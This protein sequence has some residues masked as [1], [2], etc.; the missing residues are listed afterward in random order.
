MG[1]IQD[2]LLNSTAAQA[3]LWVQL[4]NNATGTAYVSTGST[5][6]NGLFTVQNVPAGTYTLNS[7][8]TNVGPW[9]T[10][11][12]AYTVADRTPWYDVMDYGAKGDGTTD[13]TAAIQ[14][15]IN[16][17]GATGTVLFPAGFTYKI[18]ST[19]VPPQAGGQ[20]WEG[21]G[22]TIKWAGNTNSV[23]ISNTNV[24]GVTFLNF[25]M[26]GFLLDA[27]SVSGVTPLLL[28][29]W[30]AGYLEDITI[31]HVTGGSTPAVR[32]E[33]NAGTTSA[34]NSTDNV[35]RNLHIRVAPVGL[36]MV[37]QGSG[38]TNNFVTNNT[39]HGLTM[40]AVHVIGIS[41]TQ[42]C[43]S[44]NFHTC[45]I[46][47]DTNNAVGIIFNNSGAP[48]TNKG[49]YNERFFGLGIAS[50]AIT[51]AVGLQFNNSKQIFVQGFYHSPDPFNGTLVQDVHLQ[52]NSYYITETDD[53]IDNNI[54]M[55]SKGAYSYNTGSQFPPGT[56]DFANV[57]AYGAVGNN[58]A[59][60][61][62]A[63]NRAIA[64]IQTP[65]VQPTISGFSS[66]STGGTLSGNT[67][68][69][70]KITATNPWGETT[71]AAEYSFTTPAGTNTNT[72][73]LNWAQI[74]G[75]ANYKIYGRATGAEGFIAFASGSLATSYTDTGS[76][77]P[78]GAPPTLDSTVSGG[79]VY[80]PPGVYRVNSNLTPINYPNVS[81]IGSGTRATK[82]FY[83]GSGDC[84]RIQMNPFTTDQ[85][86]KF[87]GFMIDGLNAA[88][89]AVGIHYG[90]TIGGHLDDIHIR[91]FLGAGSIALWLD[92]R[93]NW[94]ERTLMTRVWLQ[95]ST[96]DML[97]DVNGSS[98]T[99]FAYTRILD[100]RLN[101][102]ANQM[103]M[104]WQN[105][106]N[107]YNSILTVLGNYVGNGVTFWQMGG[108]GNGFL[109]N[110]HMEVQAEL[111]SGTGNGLI[112]NNGSQVSGDGLIALTIGSP[113]NT[114]N[115]LFSVSGS[116]NV[117]GIITRNGA[118]QTLGGIEI[119]AAGTGGSAIVQPG[120]WSDGT[121]LFLS[122]L[123]AG[124]GGIVIR[125]QGSQVAT[126]QSIFQNNGNLQVTA[127]T[128]M[129]TSASGALQFGLTN[130]TSIRLGG[131]G[132]VTGIGISGAAASNIGV[133]VSHSL[134]TSSAVAAGFRVQSTLTAIANNDGIRGIDI[135]ATFT[136]GTGTFTGLD[137][138]LL[139]INGL[140]ATTGTG[141]IATMYAAR[142]DTPT[143]GTTNY[144]IYVNGASA[145]TFTV[146]PTG[147]TNFALQ[148]D[149]S[150]ASAATGLKVTAAAAASGVALAVISS[151]T[152]ENLTI[153]AKG[154]GTVT[155]N[156][157]ATG[158]ITLGHGTTVT[159]GGLTVS[160]GPIIGN[161]SSDAFS[162]A[163]TITVDSTKGN[164]H[165]IAAT[166]NT[167]STL[168]PSAAGTAGQHMWIRITA[169]ATGGN[170][171]TFASTFKPS[172]T[173]TLTANKGHMFHFVS[174]GTNWWE[175]ARTLA[176]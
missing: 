137:V 170:V 163:I 144:G 132:V 94:T 101:V 47:L 23:M 2:F 1:T 80:F 141:T 171:I 147:S 6:V 133:L 108:T 4:V 20:N 99:S 160:A 176:L 40:D 28:Q 118:L 76:P 52:A 68:Y 53:D 111:M 140:I 123:N 168:T 142:F 78:G 69:Y 70:Y 5:G 173:A 30:T 75:A 156:G 64:A 11:D 13:D 109:L 150:A 46:A 56:V 91:N 155:I 43:D 158:G 121:S 86:G 29:S 88:A 18:T 169:D 166:S 33:N 96:T 48:T 164:L 57:M 125:P 36:T 136:V 74:D 65:L 102:N 126:N 10:V 130:A 95:N 162:G 112:I 97:V 120:A 161:S 79:V 87:G 34:N 9:S 89:G 93:T 61:T 21:Y 85:A 124:S 135:P 127:G 106:A 12:T 138:R 77:A 59:D 63:I 37:G 7:G 66:N 117:P 39:F 51:G 8:P 90:D 31:D 110:S 26:K 62:A 19:L 149:T 152:P 45:R 98:F 49:V 122:A 154:T 24:A 128:Q 3:N 114:N 131:S 84:I 14:S 67:T 82:I 113:T 27:G 22:A 72:I 58:V 119:T 115:G 148:V 134:N 146:A 81:L 17:A 92:N 129:D 139:Y 174:D 54:R 151:G 167:A 105:G 55:V 104:Q 16:A 175:V 172:G 35:I 44:N 107:M 42:F 73:T 83:W 116:L 41:F 60:D 25:G 145:R 15:A 157:T 32:M 100:L 103:G 143:A 38:S 71:P 50:F 153:D 165:T 159:T